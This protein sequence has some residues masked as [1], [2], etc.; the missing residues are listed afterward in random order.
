MDSNK[1]PTEL[2]QAVNRASE[3]LLTTREQDLLESLM[4][5]MEIVGEVLNVDR[6][7]IWRNEVINGVLNFV[8]RY[9]WLS[10]VGKEKIEVPLGL[11]FPYT[12]IPCWYEKFVRGECINAPISQLAPNEAEFLGYYEM[13]AIVIIPLF[14]YDEFIGFF[15]VDDCKEERVFTDDEMDVLAST[16]LMFASVFNRVLQDNKLETALEQ[17]ISASRAKTNFLATMSHEMRT[18]MNA[19]IGMTAIAKKTENNKRK[20]YA[21]DKVEEAAH[22]LLGVINAVLDMSKIEANK[23][24][25]QPVEFELHRVL[26][27]VVTLVKFRMEEKMQHFNVSINNDVPRYYIGDDQRLTQIITNL[28]TNAVIYTP[29]EGKITLHVSVLKENQNNQDNQKDEDAIC[30]LLF[31]ITDTGIGISPEH[32]ERLFGMFEQADGS[33]SRKYGGTGLGLT[34]SKKLVELMGGNIS[35]ESELGKGSTFTF[36]V[37]L[38]KLETIYNNKHENDILWEE[39]NFH[40]KKILFVE[41]IE[42]NR[43][44]VI[45]QLDG[46]GLEIDIAIN[47]VEAVKMIE[48]E[49]TRYDLIFMDMRMPEMDGLQ[50]SR[51]I[52]S[53]PSDYAKK[54]P[55]IAMTANVFIDDIEQCLTAGMNDHIGKPVDMAIIFE[56]LRKYL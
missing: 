24:E 55:I 45:S 16:G 37:K 43:D 13:K 38:Q 14:L 19:I 10:E 7:Q 15:S 12:R 25:L 53:L 22:H 5:A 49:E 8:M 18:P 9:E 56:K 20:E 3:I 29:Q 21:L 35:V 11:H 50:A 27:K 1:Y 33:S 2:L 17:A 54:I 28:L 23:M 39:N 47:G 52:R 6:V 51:K 30:K 48:K 42:I 34:I 31:Q 46:T 26:Q 41:D 44:I 36:M 40:G 32:K 4:D